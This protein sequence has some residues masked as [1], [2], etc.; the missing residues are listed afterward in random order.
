MRTVL[1]ALDTTAAARPVLETALALG[2]L[3]AAAVE[4]VHVRDGPAETPETLAD[5]SGVALQ[6][7]DGPVEP[8]LL[9]ALAAPDVVAAVLGAR[10]TP[11]D[12]RPTG[13]TA[14]RVLQLAQKPTVVVP[15]AAFDNPPHPFR[16]LLL[17]L[18]GSEE[19]TRAV[20]EGVLPLLNDEVELV[21]LHVFTPTTA[22]RFLDRPARDLELLSD[23]FLSCHCP[24]ATKVHLRTGSV[25]GRV[26]ELCTEEA[27]DLIVLSWAQ[28]MESGHAAVVR[29]VLVHAEVPVLLVPVAVAWPTVLPPA[30]QR[31]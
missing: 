29:D 6:L 22:P 31:V 2:R 24:S 10:A 15:P 7:L 26:G 9:H 11:G 20:M 30:L 13:H 4:A 1:A 27:A 21:V 19:S 16:R 5:R 14:L 23:E 17:P 3:T 25:S 18:E 12:Q 28:T 8:A